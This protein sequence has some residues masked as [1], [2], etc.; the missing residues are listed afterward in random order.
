MNRIDEKRLETLSPFE[1]KNTLIDLAQNANDKS[2]VN[3]GRGNPN[4]VA[5]APREA[6]FQLG[7]FALEESKSTFSGYQGFGGMG[8]KQDVSLRFMKFCEKYEF[9]EV[10][11]IYKIIQEEEGFHHKLG[12]EILERML[13]DDGQL[14]KAKS[15][16]DKMLNVVDDMQ[17]MAAL[18]MGLHYLP[19]C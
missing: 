4:W 14:D 9:K 15:I 16:I 17:E 11:E 10:L 3:A 2:M 5:T 19:G 1:V 18:K 7:M 8:E 6:F 13:K 12:V